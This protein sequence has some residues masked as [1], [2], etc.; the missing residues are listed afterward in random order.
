[1]R[2]TLLQG[3]RLRD[4][5]GLWT[6]TPVAGGV[7]LRHQIQLDPDLPALLR[8]TYF[9]LTEANLVQSMLILRRLML[10]G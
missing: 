5:S 8:S 1:M 4:L 3:D 7:Q 10:Q 9:E 2:Y 6:I